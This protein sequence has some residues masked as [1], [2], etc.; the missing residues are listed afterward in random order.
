M[1]CFRVQAGRNGRTGELGNVCGMRKHH[2][3]VLRVRS[4]PASLTVLGL[5]KQVLCKM[6]LCQ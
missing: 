3:V 5:A 4:A 6:L 2:C 1:T